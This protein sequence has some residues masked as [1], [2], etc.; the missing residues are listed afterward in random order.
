MIG[1]RLCELAVLFAPYALL[2]SLVGLIS[3]SA[4]AH[5]GGLDA[6]G[7]HNDRRHGGY[8]CHCGQVPGQSFSSKTEM[9]Q[10]LEGGTKWSTQPNTLR[11]APQLRNAECGHKRTCSQMTSCE[12]A[13]I[14]MTRCGSSRLDGDGD[15][16]PCESLCR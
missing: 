8:H 13:M 10:L 3:S 2:G 4:L 5:G 12:E 15:G 6:Y 1:G 11:S 9:L 7:C 16:L 14:Y